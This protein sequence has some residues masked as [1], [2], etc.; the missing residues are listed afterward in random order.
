[1]DIMDRRKDIEA[2][3]KHCRRKERNQYV[4]LLVRGKIV[5]PNRKLRIVA[6]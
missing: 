2:C 5:K 4:M 1:M 6:N 3:L